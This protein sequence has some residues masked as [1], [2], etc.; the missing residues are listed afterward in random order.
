MSI[1]DRLMCFMNMNYGK[2]KWLI[3]L[4]NGIHHFRYF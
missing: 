2:L 1:S 3:A 4:V